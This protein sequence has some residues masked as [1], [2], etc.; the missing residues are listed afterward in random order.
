MLRLPGGIPGCSLPN[1][2]SRAT[3]PHGTG[4]NGPVNF[5]VGR[6]EP[7]RR[8]E[9]RDL[10]GMRRSRPLAARPIQKS[11]QTEKGLKY[12]TPNEIGSG[13]M[14]RFGGP[15]ENPDPRRA[16]RPRPLTNQ[17]RFADSGITLDHSEKRF[18]PL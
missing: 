14:N 8:P 4:A 3:L 15:R 10:L 18:S 13:R 9:I 1:A 7:T 5:E 6:S 17:G 11:R 16:G 12:W 2:L